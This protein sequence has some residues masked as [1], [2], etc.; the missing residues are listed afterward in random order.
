MPWPWPPTVS[1]A[2]SA[3]LT[4]SADVLL[5]VVDV[6]VRPQSEDEVAVVGGAGRDHPGA[7]HLG[8]LDRQMTDTARCA[9]DHDGLPLRQAA[10]VEQSLP[11]GEPRSLPPP[12]AHG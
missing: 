5:G 1:N 10:C 4:V 9:G 11:G 2:T 3:S 8:E 12:P 6:L 7:R